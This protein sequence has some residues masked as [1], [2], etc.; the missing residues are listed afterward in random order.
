LGTDF[1]DYTELEELNNEDYFLVYTHGCYP[2]SFDNRD[3]PPYAISIPVRP[4]DSFAEHLVLQPRGAFA[5]I[6]NTRYGWGA[7]NSLQSSSQAYHR[8][9]WNEIVANDRRGLGELMQVSKENLINFIDSKYNRWV[10]LELTLIG[11]PEVDLKIPVTGRAAYISEPYLD[12]VRRDPFPLMGTIKG[13][14]LQSWTVEIGEGYHPSSWQEIGH[15]ISTVID[16]PI[17]SEIVPGI[18][19][20]GNYRLRLT[21]NYNDEHLTHETVFAVGGNVYIT[22][23]E[24]KSLYT[25]EK[26]I[27]I[28]GTIYIDDLMDFNVSYGFG[29]NP[30]DWY[31]EGVVKYFIGDPIYDDVLASIDIDEIPSF[32]KA[33]PLTVKINIER[34]IAQDFEDKRTV[35]VFH[36]MKNGWPKFD[37]NEISEG[38]RFLSSFPAD[39][40]NDGESEIYMATES[41]EYD[42]QNFINFAAYDTEG[43]IIPKWPVTIPTTNNNSIS[44]Y[45]SYDG[46]TLVYSS[47]QEL[48]ILDI[49]EP[50]NA[51][52]IR[53]G[54]T[55]AYNT[56]T[57]ANIQGDEE[58]EIVIAGSDQNND[59][60]IYAYSKDGTLVLDLPIDSQLHGSHIA[61]ADVD[62]DFFDELFFVDS[63]GIGKLYMIDDGEIAWIKDF[64][65]QQRPLTDPVIGDID[66]DGVADIVTVSDIDSYP[67]IHAIDPIGNELPGFPANELYNIMMSQT[68]NRV[69]LGNLDGESGDEIIVPMTNGFHVYKGDGEGLYPY[70]TILLKPMIPLLLDGDDDGYQDIFGIHTSLFTNELKAFNNA[71]EL[72]TGYPWDIPYINAELITDF[73]N[74]GQELGWGHSNSEMIIIDVDNDGLQELMLSHIAD[75][76]ELQMGHINNDKFG[77]YIFDLDVPMNDAIWNYQYA[78]PERTN[79]IFRIIA[80]PANCGNAEI[81]QGEVCDGENL[82]DETCISQGFDA[83][84]LRCRGNCQ[85]FDIKDCLVIEDTLAEAKKHTVR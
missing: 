72:I 58:K 38:Q 66:S 6:G 14:G 83:G 2:S 71:Q 75:S 81:D 28:I 63:S 24:N 56:P 53:C 82:Q 7:Q 37:I 3:H 64:G 73:S 19:S 12:E 20:N 13:S 70:P 10:Y 60:R 69:L 9:F 11:D 1:G 34:S 39:T 77:V 8:E 40:D 18:M 55:C 74:D 32:S 76:M 27:D 41:K 79:S 35:Y 25:P 17:S 22:L 46:D 84:Q 61:A 85:S 43:Q 67:I 52:K 54:E 68:Q 36:N 57:I 80:D 49:D 5:F 31:T 44:N 26:N 4:Y 16:G 48:F 59:D 15:G 78:N 30:E 23:P 21:A 51:F 62:D 50:S 65:Q 33:Y 42:I 47:S 29:E 45:F